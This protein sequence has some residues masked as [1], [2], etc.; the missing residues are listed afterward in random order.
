[1]PAPNSILYSLFFLS[2]HPVTNMTS[3]KSSS[4]YI[5]YIT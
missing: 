4:D 5:L 3:D 2:V 1:M